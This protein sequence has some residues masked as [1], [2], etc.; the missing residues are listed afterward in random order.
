MQITLSLA[1]EHRTKDHTY[2]LNQG[3]TITDYNSNSTTWVV[4]KIIGGQFIATVLE[5]APIQEWIATID[6][7]S[8]SYT[9]F[10]LLL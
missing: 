3:R 2:F 6:H 1:L 7:I 8:I 9:V 5:T 4:L 10:Y